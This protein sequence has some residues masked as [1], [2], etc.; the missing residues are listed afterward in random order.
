[1]SNCLVAS[2]AW[3]GVRENRQDFPVFTSLPP[4]GDCEV[5]SFSQTSRGA[6]S[7]NW[8]D[9]H[10]SPEGESQSQPW[11]RSTLS[12]RNSRRNKFSVARLSMVERT[13]TSTLLG[14][15]KDRNLD[16][17]NDE[18]A[19][20]NKNWQQPTGFIWRISQGEILCLEG[21]SSGSTN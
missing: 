10:S 17:K 1:M 3:V 9:M 13:C 4:W 12:T 16:S 6:L 21:G 7:R 2:S 14:N 5:K 8:K 15:F 11:F 18:T 20:Y 19:H